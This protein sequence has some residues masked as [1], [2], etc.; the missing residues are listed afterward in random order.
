[1]RRLIEHTSQ[2]ICETTIVFGFHSRSASFRCPSYFF[3]Q[4]ITHS[5]GQDITHSPVAVQASFAARASLWF[6]DQKFLCRQNQATIDKIRRPN[7][8][9]PN[10]SQNFSPIFVVNL[11]LASMM[12]LAL[13]MARCLNDGSWPQR[14]PAAPTMALCLDGS[15]D[16]L[17]S[18]ALWPRLRLP[19]WLMGEALCLGEALFMAHA[20]I[21]WMEGSM[22]SRPPPSYSVSSTPYDHPL[23]HACYRGN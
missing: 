12:A 9:Q 10:L 13:T 3:G 6:V 11:C 15:F 23:L 16:P 14:W 21:R 20:V 4:D 17:G 22:I 2:N 19:T 7:I 18:L 5:P 1:V 8:C